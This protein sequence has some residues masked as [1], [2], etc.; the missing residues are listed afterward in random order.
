MIAAGNKA[1]IEKLKENKHKKGFDDI[2][3]MYA[4]GR[5]AEEFLELEREIVFTENIDEI[6]KEAADVANF[7]HMIILRCDQI[8]KNS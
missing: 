5:L 1:Q 4:F 3:I 2:D 6:R 8:L 7:A